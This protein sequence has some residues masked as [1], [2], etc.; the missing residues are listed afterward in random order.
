M[1]VPT[2]ELQAFERICFQIEQAWWFYED[3][4]RE[5]DASLPKLNLREFTLAGARSA[6]G[7]DGSGSGG[8]GGG[9]RAGPTPT[10]RAL[11]HT[12]SRA[13]AMRLLAVFQHVPMLQRFVGRFDI[14]FQR[15]LDYKHSVPVCGAILLSPAMDKCV[16]VKGWSAKAGWSFPRG[17]INQQE[18]MHKCATREVRTYTAAAGLA[19]IQAC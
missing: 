15:F 1:N 18:E 4:Y 11:T 8:G 13:H 10:H 5:R 16:L 17:K 7:G 14:V 3:H 9:R 2:E 6:C 12:R 19:H